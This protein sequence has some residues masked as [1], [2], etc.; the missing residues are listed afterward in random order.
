M[1]ARFLYK[2]RYI[3]ALLAAVFAAALVWLWPP[4]PLWRS[5]PNVGHL[6]SF[7]PDGTIIV[8]TVIPWP[9]VNAYLD[10]VIYRWDASS[11]QMLSRVILPCS[12][13]KAM[14]RVLTSTDGR[15]AMVGEGTSGPAQVLFD[16]G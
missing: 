1:L 14:K 4:R 8:T 5:P 15:L 2:C 12:Q 16:S 10:P 13:P 7:S 11:G 6:N 9:G 3:F